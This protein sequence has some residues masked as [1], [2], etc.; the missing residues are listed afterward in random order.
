MYYCIMNDLSVTAG[1][2]D[3][4]EGKKKT[5]GILH[6]YVKAASNTSN[7]STN[8]IL[9]YLQLMRLH[10]Q[11]QRHPSSSKHIIHSHSEKH[12]IDD[13]K[14]LSLGKT[15]ILFILKSFN[16][17]KKKTEFKFST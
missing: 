5:Q 16:G 7:I 10:L 15:S 1:T 9:C 12:I 8:M 14:I 4:G 3:R 13:E 6:V 17:Q 11:K 2:S